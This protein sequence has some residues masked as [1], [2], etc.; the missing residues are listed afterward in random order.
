MSMKEGGNESFKVSS[1][2]LSK[3]YQQKTTK[4]C[5]CMCFE[6]QGIERKN[7]FDNK[8]I[9][10]REQNLILL[11]HSLNCVWKKLNL[12]VSHNVYYQ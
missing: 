7:S 10:V 12:Y 9:G 6:T 3:N 8:C 1:V 2:Y 4:E 5:E 11:H